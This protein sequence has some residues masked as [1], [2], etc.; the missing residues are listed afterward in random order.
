MSSL[1]DKSTFDKLGDGSGKGVSVSTSNK[2]ECTSCEQKNDDDGSSDNTSGSCNSDIGAVAEG[3]SKANISNDDNNTGIG[4]VDI[5]SVN[6]TG[7]NSSAEYSLAMSDEKL[8]ADPP[9]KEDCPICMLPIPYA[10]GLCDVR[11]T[12]MPCCGKMFCLGCMIAANGEMRKGNMKRLCAFCRLPLYTSDEECLKRV[13][14][15]TKLNDPDAFHELGATYHNGIRGLPKDMSKAIEL[16]KQAAELGSVRAHN[17]LANAYQHNQGV[18]EDMEKAMYHMTLAAI[19]GHEYARHALGNVEKEKGNYNRAVKHFLIAARSGNDASL[20]QVGGAY[21]AGGDI[22]TKDEYTTTL[23]AYQNSKD[24][25]K[26]AQ[27]SEGSELYSM[28]KKSR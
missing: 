23:R 17:A 12:Y 25:M 8:F 5:S 3:V 26:S 21:K 27:R 1:D 28:M 7:S 22:V 15:R 9:P 10:S 2:K 20:K 6:N 4:R 19:G 16:W 18:E 11:K 24:E 13:K 14:E